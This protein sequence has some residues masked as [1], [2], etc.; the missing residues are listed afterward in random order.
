MFNTRVRQLADAVDELGVHLAG[1]ASA[2]HARAARKNQGEHPELPRACA[3]RK[4]YLDDNGVVTEAYEWFGYKF[5]LLVDTKHEV[6]VG[7]RITAANV[8]DGK[9]LPAVLADARENLG[10]AEEDEANGAKPHAGR[11]QTLA[12]DKACDRSQVHELLGQY[13]IGGVIE[14]RAMWRENPERM[15]PGDDGNENVVYDEE[16]TLYCYDKISDPPVRHRM[17]YFGFEKD[18]GTLK[19]RCPARHEGW[20]CPSD[21]RCNGGKKY[22]KTKRVKC[23]IEPRRFCRVPRG[24]KKFQRLYKGRTAVERVNSR[25]KVF[26]GMDDGNVTGNQR[27]AAKFG[28]V[29]LTH[30]TFATLL[31]RAERWDG[32][33]SQTRLTPIAKALR[34]TDEP[35]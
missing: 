26:W 4:E 34:K 8:D 12:Y 28:T 32:T 20:R 31:A 25:L 16:G 11:I 6:V 7:Y 19:Y 24:T 10:D 15:L 9:A 1:D 30:I 29:M 14:T 17:A 23:E 27:F 21:Q 18:R 3:G 13:G 2:L 22:G 33:L 35:V 5:H